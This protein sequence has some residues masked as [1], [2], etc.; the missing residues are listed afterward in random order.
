LHTSTWAR[1]SWR[2]APQRS[3]SIVV[4][5]VSHGVWNGLVYV[6]FGFGTTLGA[7]GIRNTGV[8]GPELNLAFAVGMWLWSTRGRAI[9]AV[10]MARPLGPSG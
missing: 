2:L 3:G 4:T 1:R 7:L 6:F 10:E 8:L 5:A 9:Q